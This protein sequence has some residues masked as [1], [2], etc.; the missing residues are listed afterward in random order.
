[1]ILAIEHDGNLK[2]ELQDQ[3]GETALDLAVEQTLEIIELLSQSR[4]I[5]MSIVDSWGELCSESLC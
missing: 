5:D 2:L 4:G 3:G 1:M